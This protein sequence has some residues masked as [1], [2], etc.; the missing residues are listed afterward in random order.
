MSSGE[1]ATDKS[2]AVAPSITCLLKDQTS[3]WERA[4]MALG[5]PGFIPFGTVTSIVLSEIGIQVSY[6]VLG[7][8]VWVVHP[9]NRGQLVSRLTNSRQT[10]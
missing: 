1:S 7:D 6:L 2:I 3:L 10:S 8:Q 4:G 9:C 5:R